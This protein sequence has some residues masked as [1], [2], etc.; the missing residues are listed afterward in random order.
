MDFI[1]RYF[2][3][4]ILFSMILSII[5]NYKNLLIASEKWS[6]NK[7]KSVTYAQVAGEVQHGD[8]LG[9]FISVNSNCDKVWNTFSFLTFENKDNMKQILDKHLPIKLNGVE[10]TAK[11]ESVN[12][13]SHGYQVI[14]SLGVFPIKE[15]IYFLNEFYAEQKKYEIEIIDGINFK[16]EKYFDIQIN[17]WKLENLV[18]SVSKAN[19][20]CREII[21]NTKSS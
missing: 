10:L 18:E 7:Y 2:K 15:Y 4:I 3:K 6:V 9:F 14:F 11:V 19:K 12:R 8:T 16:A 20:M 5:L 17:N 1:L 21:A 13:F